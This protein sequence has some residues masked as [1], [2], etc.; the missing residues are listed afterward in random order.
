M[1]LWIDHLIFGNGRGL[2]SPYF[3]NRFYWLS[4]RLYTFMHGHGA[5]L[6]SFQWL[7]PKAGE[8][9]KLSGRDYRVFHS[10][11]RWLRVVVAW[12]TRLPDDIDA[13]N[14]MLH[15]IKAGLGEAL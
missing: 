8:V 6:H 5:Q 2:R 15:A 13:A 12:S 14:T 11:R 1:M 3:D 10:T 4:G 9:R 7:H